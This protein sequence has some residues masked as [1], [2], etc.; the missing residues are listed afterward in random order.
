MENNY[1]V[2]IYYRLDTNEP[3]YVGKGKDNRCTDFHSRNDWFM[4]IVDKHRVAVVVEKDN[5]TQSEAFYWE[6]EIIRILV[7][8]YGYSINIKGNYYEDDKSFCHLVN[9][10]WGGEGSSGYH[11]TEEW[12]K[13]VGENSSNWWK[14]T[15]EDT[16]LAR[17]KKISSARIGWSP[18]ES[19]RK[20]MSE[21]NLGTNSPSARSIICLTTKKIFLT[22]KD[23]VDYYVTPH[24]EGISQCCSGYKRKGSDSRVL[25]SGKL[26]DGT[27]LV[28]RYLNYNHNK[29]YQINDF[30]LNK[31]RCF[32]V[33]DNLD[34]LRVIQHKKRIMTNNS[35]NKYWICLTT[36]KMFTNLEDAS[37]LYNI[38]SKG[39]I[40]RVCNGKRK[41]TGKDKNGNKLVW[42]YL[43]VDHN[44]K[45]RIK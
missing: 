27:P 6:E 14:N 41:T 8:E 30:I 20:K 16:I 26:I 44:K 21:N 2:Y 19:T 5:L 43:I 35:K 4:N 13:R 17:N 12:K 36:K 7:F 32:K 29:T 33:K 42:K 31:I 18:S 45:Y 38:K 10:T 34:N 37:L 24:S 25:S 23:G 3:F 11:H 40:I 22:I 39:N 28:W 9:A 15:D 1:Y